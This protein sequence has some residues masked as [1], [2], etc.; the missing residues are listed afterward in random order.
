METKLYVGSLA[1]SITNDQL[2]AIFSTVGHV[3]DAKLI[4]DTATGRSKGFGFVTMSTQQ[5]AEKAISELN[6]TMQGGRAIIVSKARPDNKTGGGGRGGFGGGGGGR[7]GSGGRG[8][9]GGGGRSDRGGDRG[10][11]GGRY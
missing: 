9:F 2:A 5:E 10:G 7:G 6:G 8:G 4:I 11:N 1:Y 3:V